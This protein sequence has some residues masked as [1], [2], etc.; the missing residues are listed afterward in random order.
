[1]KCSGFAFQE[2]HGSELA[3]Q[4]SFGAAIGP[5]HTVAPH[6]TSAAGNS[7]GCKGAGRIRIGDRHCAWAM[8]DGRLRSDNLGVNRLKQLETP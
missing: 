5:R 2:N 4:A 6:G 3:E 1:M 7:V 8:E